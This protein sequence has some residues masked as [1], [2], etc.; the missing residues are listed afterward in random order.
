MEN[1]E[2]Y[3]DAGENL[4]MTSKNSKINLI[5]SGVIREGNPEGINGAQWARLGA[6]SRPEY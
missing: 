5:K 2:N 6:K 1:N 3:K 4:K